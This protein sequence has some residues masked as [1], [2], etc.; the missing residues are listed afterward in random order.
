MSPRRYIENIGFL[1]ILAEAQPTTLE[2][3][4]R[5]DNAQRITELRSRYFMEITEPSSVE[6]L[7][8]QARGIPANVAEPG[9][10][11]RGS[12]VSATFRLRLVSLDRRH[13]I[14][15]L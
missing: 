10:Q 15:N 1:P 12:D 13:Q 14:T 5:I 7:F 9:Y 6:Y 11:G 2:L 8:G 4:R 3:R